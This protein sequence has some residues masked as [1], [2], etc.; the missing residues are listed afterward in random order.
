MERT[1]T[2]NGG[3][4]ASKPVLTSL[5]AAQSFKI[6]SF[7]LRYYSL[8]MLAAV[9]CGYFL[10]RVRAIKEGISLKLFDDLAF[11]LVVGGFLGARIYEVLSYLPYYKSNPG[12]IIKIWHGGL[13]IYGAIIAGALITF[14]FAR[15]HK[16]PFLKL[17]DLIA[18][19]L[20]LSQ[21]IGRLGN[22]FNHEAFG[23]PTNLP[24][25][26][27][28]PQ[29]SRPAGF[30]N[31][32]YFHPTF[33]YEGIWN[34]IVFFILIFIAKKLKRSSDRP[35]VITASYLFLY[36]I[37]RFWIESIRLDSA[38]MGSLKTNQITA[39]LLIFVS[40]AIMIFRYAPQTDK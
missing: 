25:K 12:E 35:G 2:K 34:L 13:S 24:W 27:F 26:I 1:G 11:W 16:I 4:K 23:K 5:L 17:S 18:F 21:A 7:S 15:K 38:F 19:S 10:A 32:A 40:F 37:G 30:E 39:L 9:L 14:I 29:G 6:G 31:Y 22:Y 20:P 8:T 28:I 36:S 3:A 33:L